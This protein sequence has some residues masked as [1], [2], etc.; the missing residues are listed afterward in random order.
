MLRVQLRGPPRRGVLALSEPRL[1]IRPLQ[2]LHVRLR[3]HPCQHLEVPGAHVFQAK[4]E[5]YA[6]EDLST[7]LMFQ[8]VRLYDEG[9][10]K[11]IYYR[12]RGHRK[13]EQRRVADE[14]RES[15]LAGG[16]EEIIRE[17]GRRGIR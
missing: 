17:D 10:H 11:A 8:Q 1:P 9:F 12:P 7:A 2:R 6:R 15:N 14:D 13:H 4:K 16:F 5:D 3:L